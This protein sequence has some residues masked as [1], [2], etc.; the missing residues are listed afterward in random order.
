MVSFYQVVGTNAPVKGYFF[1]MASKKCRGRELNIKISIKKT[2][3]VTTHVSEVHKV[4]SNRGQS[5]KQK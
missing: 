2:M 1:C 4:M 5:V 3:A